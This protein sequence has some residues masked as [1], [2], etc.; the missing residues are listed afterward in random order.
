VSHPHLRHGAIVLAV[1]LA[2]CSTEKKTA[3]T[4][5]SAAK[6]DIATTPAG[7]NVVTITAKDYS[8][9]APD[10]VPAGLTTVRLVSDGKEMHHVQF[11]KLDSGKTVADFEKA[12]KNP[13]PPPRWAVDHGG[14]NPPRPG[15]GIA[16]ATQQL[17]PGNYAIVCFVPGPDGVPHVMK[18]MARA[19][20]VTPSTG[21]SAPEPNADV[22]V[23]LA[24][25]TFEPSAPLTAGKHTIRVE[26]DGQ[27][28]HE[29]VLVRLAPGKTAK[30]VATWV[31]KMQGP[32]PGEPVGGVSAI[33]P[34]AHQFFTV[35]LTPGQ[36]GMLCFI[37]DMKDGKPHVAHGMVK[38]ITVN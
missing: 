19:L 17:E 12:L 2:A 5:D 30:D 32:P 11:V 3:A 23:R 34:H 38:Q 22:T 9:E 36:Y 24:D 8:F 26:N 31:E 33:P 14:V 25:Y 1:A 6:P 28:S 10:S 4:A 21:A 20:T 7:P 37:P 15:G 13:G 18:G 29:I 16:E 27:Q 35:D